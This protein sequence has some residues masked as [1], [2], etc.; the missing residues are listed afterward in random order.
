MTKY[1][2]RKR[3]TRLSLAFNLII[4]YACFLY[5]VAGITKHYA[6]LPRPESRAER[7]SSSP[8]PDL[9]ADVLQ[10]PNSVSRSGGVEPGVAGQPSQAVKDT[11]AKVCKENFQG[12]EASKCYVRLLA[13]AKVESGFNPKASN[14]SAIEDSHGLFQINLRVHKNVSLEQA[15]D[16]EYATRWTIRRLLAYGYP[17]KGGHDTT[18]IIQTHNGVN[19]KKEDPFAYARQVRAIALSYERQGL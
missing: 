5:T 8:A 2:S 18:Y 14:V 1:Q 13:I 17:G 11:I 12:G 7:V 15:Q 6:N 16:V 4:L 9:D 10:A 3:L 19:M